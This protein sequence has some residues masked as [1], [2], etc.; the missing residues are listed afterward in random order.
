M[1]QLF[2][3][4]RR[5]SVLAGRGTNL[6]ALEQHILLRGSE[7]HG[8][9]AVRTVIRRAV[10][11]S[12]QTASL[13]SRVARLHGR[14]HIECLQTV[15]ENGQPRDRNTLPTL[16]VRK[17][18]QIVSIFGEGG[19]QEEGVT[20]LAGVATGGLVDA[21]CGLDLEVSVAIVGVAAMVGV[22][23]GLLPKCERGAAGGCDGGADREVAA[24]V[25]AV[26]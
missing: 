26:S 12:H 3:R 1:V 25:D 8:Y 13:K 22:R 14:Q 19:V 15:R 10:L 16:D 4:G 18:V 21:V 24:D 11:G 6:R 20:D 2:T 5:V 7:A 23:E 9:C 17:N